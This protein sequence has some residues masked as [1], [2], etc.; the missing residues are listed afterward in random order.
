MSRKSELLKNISEH[1]P[2]LDIEIN[3]IDLKILKSLRTNLL[4]TSDER[5]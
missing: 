1:L 2:K 5:H 4:E 3:D